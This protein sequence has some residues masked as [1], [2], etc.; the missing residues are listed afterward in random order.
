MARSTV[1]QWTHGTVPEDG[2]VVVPLLARA[3]EVPL[4]NLIP[5]LEQDDYGK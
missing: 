2:L 3:L 5:P 1:Y 4:R